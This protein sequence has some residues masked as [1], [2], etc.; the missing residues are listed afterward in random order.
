MDLHAEVVGIAGRQTQA[1]HQVFSQTSAVFL[2]LLEWFF[3]LKP[4]D[5]VLDEDLIFI[6][7][8]HRKEEEIKGGT[9]SVTFVGTYHCLQESK[10]HPWPGGVL[11]VWDGVRVNCLQTIPHPDFWS[12]L[13]WNF[14][15]QKQ[16]YS[17][18]FPTCPSPGSL[19]HPLDT[20]GS[21]VCEGKQAW[22]K[23]GREPWQGA[24][25]SPMFKSKSSSKV[26]LFTSFICLVHGCLIHRTNVYPDD[27]VRYDYD[28]ICDFCLLQLACSPKNKKASVRLT[29]MFLAILSIN[30]CFFLSCFKA[31]SK[32]QCLL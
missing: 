18:G 4:E 32:Y 30:A 17:V 3:S 27:G 5:Y 11:T 29:Y 2:K 10:P 20:Y 21:K 31:T 26:C 15:S 12:W 7:I 1:H 8:L 14:K 19:N 9:L 25:L 13:L 6:P 23:P 16:G 24:A 28:L 22:R